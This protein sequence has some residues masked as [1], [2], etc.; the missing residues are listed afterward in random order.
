MWYDR[1]CDTTIC[2]VLLDLQHMDFF[3]QNQG[4]ERCFQAEVKRDRVGSTTPL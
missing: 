2:C 1:F 4:A 3:V